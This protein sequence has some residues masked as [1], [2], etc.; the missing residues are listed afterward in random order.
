MHRLLM[1]RLLM[2]RLLMHRLLMHRLLMHRLL[3][4]RLL[5]HGTAE[6]DIAVDR[7]LEPAPCDGLA[8]VGSRGD[9]SLRRR[10]M[11]IAQRKRGDALADAARVAIQRLTSA[12][13]K[14]RVDGKGDAAISV[15]AMGTLLGVVTVTR[16]AVE[17]VRKWY[18][19]VSGV[20]GAG[21][22][23]PVEPG[24]AS[25]LG[26][27]MSV[28]SRRQLICRRVMEAAKFWGQAVSAWSGSVPQDLSLQLQTLDGDWQQYISEA[29]TM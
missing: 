8:D 23:K 3:M 26:E 9:M 28:E 15:E 20:G 6:E 25:A 21:V 10:P 29:M 19:D 24:R 4:H 16:A 7:F 1:H 2:H 11:Q 17:D 14:F 12:V 22:D 27:G 5:M 18:R 13:V